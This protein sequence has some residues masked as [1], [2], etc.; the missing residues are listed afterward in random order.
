MKEME[1]STVAQKAS[2]TALKVSISRKTSCGLRD[3][4]LKKVLCQFGRSHAVRNANYLYLAKHMQ[5]QP[6]YSM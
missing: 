2:Q 5:R 3:L 1:L 4:E 6:Q